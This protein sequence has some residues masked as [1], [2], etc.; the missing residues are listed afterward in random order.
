MM[1]G[2]DNDE[3]LQVGRGPSHD[4]V[5]SVRQVNIKKLW[6]ELSCLQCDSQY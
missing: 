3:P 6:Y 4:H 5:E 1:D 2:D